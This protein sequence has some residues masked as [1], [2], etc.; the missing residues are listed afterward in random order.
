MFGTNGKTLAAKFLVG[1][2]DVQVARFQ[3]EALN[4]P[5]QLGDNAPCVRARSAVIKVPDLPVWYFF[6]D[7][8][9]GE[10]LQ[11]MFERRRLPWSPH[12]AMGILGRIA[13]ALRSLH[14]AHLVHRDLHPGNIMVQPRDDLPTEIVLTDS[15]GI[16]FLDLGV[17]RDLYPEVKAAYDTFRP[18]GSVS[19]AGPEA[20]R[21]P[22]TAG[23]PADMWSL[24]VLLYLLL[25]G[26]KPF[27]KKSLAD[28]IDSVESRQHPQSQINGPTYEALVLNRI[29]DQL[30]AKSASARPRASDLVRMAIDFLHYGLAPRCQDKR[31]FDLYFDNNSNIVTCLHCHFVVPGTG[32]QSNKCG[33]LHGDCAH[34]SQGSLP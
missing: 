8:A 30:L 20:L 31:F 22:S 26:E 14:A 10:S 15:P 7:K 12:M 27:F 18:I 1:A 34:C 6:M 25:N 32:A 17:T 2:N 5:I 16:T 33:R 11:A 9:E 21:S 28:L 29:I 13:S 24:G 23:T 3:A 19:F 4:K